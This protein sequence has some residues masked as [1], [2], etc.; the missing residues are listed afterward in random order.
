MAAHFGLLRNVRKLLSSPF[1]D[2]NAQ[3]VH[4][5]TAGH[6]AARNHKFDAFLLIARHRQFNLNITNI[7]NTT[8]D[9]FLSSEKLPF[10]HADV[11]SA[12]DFTHFCNKKYVKMSMLVDDSRNTVLHAACC[13]SVDARRKVEYLLEA[14]RHMLLSRNVNKHLPLHLAALS[15]DVH[16][17]DAVL[18]ASCQQG[19]SVNAPDSEGMTPLH[20]AT[21]HNVRWCEHI[22]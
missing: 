15:R 6:H 14:H 18:L 20:L 2:V 12:E 9:F 3:D 22:D 11:S 8:A 19:V 21:K 16:L 17:L 13:S 1:T 5:N 4:G 10:L 7:T